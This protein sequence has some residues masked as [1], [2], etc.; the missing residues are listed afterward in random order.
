MKK[1]VKL[2][3]FIGL[4]GLAVVGV[5]KGKEYYNNRYVGTKYYAVVPKNQSTQPEMIYDNKGDEI[6]KGKTYDLKSYN[7][8]ETRVLNF[9]VYREKPEELLQPGTFL[10]IEASSEIVLGEKIIKRD[11]VPAN[12]LQEIE[13]NK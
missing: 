3:V 12:I 1:L 6:G 5:T 7:G 10:E 9:T 2:V 8:K 4:V 13:K 11:E